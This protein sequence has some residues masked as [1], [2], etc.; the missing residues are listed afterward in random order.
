MSF[1]R[2]KNCSIGFC[3]TCALQ[4]RLSP[5]EKKRNFEARL[6]LLENEEKIWDSFE[7][8]EGKKKKEFM[9]Q[10]LLPSTCFQEVFDSLVSI[11]CLTLFWDWNQFVEKEEEVEPGACFASFGIWIENWSLIFGQYRRTLEFGSRWL[12]FG[13]YWNFA[14]WRVYYFADLV[15]TRWECTW[16]NYKLI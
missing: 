7:S 10:W 8:W 13:R 11:S 15:W 2:L 14:I 1:F 12:R 4:A 3:L 5:R 6:S 16:V 9:A